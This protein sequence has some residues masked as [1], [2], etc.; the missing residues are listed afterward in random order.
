MLQGLGSSDKRLQRESM[1]VPF[2]AILTIFMFHN[3][4]TVS[5]GR[6]TAL[7]PFITTQVS[8]DDCK[9]PDHTVHPATTH[10]GASPGQ[11]LVMSK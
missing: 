1:D 6:S 10:S 7:L 3:D 11:L 9:Y 4:Y 2:P 5:P 8:A